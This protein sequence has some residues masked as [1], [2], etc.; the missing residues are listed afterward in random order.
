MRRRDLTDHDTE[1]GTILSTAT[2]IYDGNFYGYVDAFVPFLWGQ[3][4]SDLGELYA[5]SLLHRSKPLDIAKF[6]THVW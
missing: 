6:T 5:R 1:N 4:Q 3:Y 2:D